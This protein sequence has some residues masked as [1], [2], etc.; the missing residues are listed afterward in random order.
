MKDTRRVAGNNDGIDIDSSQRVTIRHCDI[1]TGHRS[2]SATLLANIA[3]KT[4]SYLE[5][6]AKAEK[7]T[8]NQAA[9]KY[10]QYQYRAP[11]K[12]T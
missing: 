5:W 6:D 2:T 8:N 7:F 3:H 1:E 9:N 4:K 11:Y 12:L 10:L